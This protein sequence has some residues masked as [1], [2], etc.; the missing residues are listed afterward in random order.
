VCA[1]ERAR[2]RERE[3]VCVVY[4]RSSTPVLW[5]NYC[6]TLPALP[7]P[8]LSVVVLRGLMLRRPWGRGQRVALEEIRY[9]QAAVLVFCHV[10]R[11]EVYS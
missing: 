7:I 1:S 9:R 6:T 10:W 2:E 3:R 4:F 5:E 8:T 11:V